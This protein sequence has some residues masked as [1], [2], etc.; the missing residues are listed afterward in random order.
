MM[1]IVEVT[2]VE[3]DADFGSLGREFPFIGVLLDEIGGHVKFPP[4]RLVDQS[5][6]IGRLLEPLRS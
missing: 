3:A 1:A 6:E 2:V 5:V 4:E